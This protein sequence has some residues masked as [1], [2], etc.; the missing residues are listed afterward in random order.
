MKLTLNQINDLNDMKASPGY[1]LYEAILKEDMDS[2]MRRLL[3]VAEKDLKDAQGRI[4]GIRYAY[5]LIE[6]TVKKTINQQTE[7]AKDG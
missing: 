3:E 5:E 1:K 2:R 6:H 7:E 4:K